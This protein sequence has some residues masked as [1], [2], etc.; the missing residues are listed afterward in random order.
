MKIENLKILLEAKFTIEQLEALEAAGVFKESTDC[1]KEEYMEHSCTCDLD[2]HDN[3]GVSIQ[4]GYCKIHN[5]GEKGFFR[6]I[7][8]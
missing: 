2:F 6:R 5:P 4:G 8:G 7:F 3:F 1:R